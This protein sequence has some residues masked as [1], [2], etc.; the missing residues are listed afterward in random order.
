V[1]SSEHF[2]DQDM[3]NAT[4]IAIA[5][6]FVAALGSISSEASAH[7]RLYPVTRC[8]PDLAYL[9]PIRGYFSQPPFHYNDAVYPGCIKRVHVETPYGVESRRTIVC[10]APERQMIWW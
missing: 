6:A 10:G 5:A 8:G 7:G 9:C 3:S 2:K 1:S 4:K